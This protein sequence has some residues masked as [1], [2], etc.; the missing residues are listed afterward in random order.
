MFS[1]CLCAASFPQTVTS[2]GTDFWIAFPPNDVSPILTIFISSNYTT[3]G[4]ITSAYPGVNQSFNVVPGI[5]TQIVLPS[6]VVLLSGT[7]NKGI[8]ITSNDPVCVYGLNHFGATTDAYLALPVNALGLDYRIM[9][10][11]VS[12]PNYG[13]GLSVVATQDGSNLSIFNHQTS[14]TSNVTLN[15]G[16]TYLLE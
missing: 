5:V 7:E 6:G 11:N 1:L 14:T 4:N 2:E 13:S 12:L 10:Y 16:Q 8:H 9:S 3:S 15:K